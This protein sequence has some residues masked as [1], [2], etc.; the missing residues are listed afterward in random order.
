M[1]VNRWTIAKR[2]AGS[3]YRES[4]EMQREGPGYFLLF[5]VL[6][7]LA[8][9]FLLL[10]IS[11]FLLSGK[12][13]GWFPALEDSARPPALVVTTEEVVAML[14][15]LK[16]QALHLV[17]TSR[18][19]RSRIGGVPDLPDGFEWPEWQNVPLAFLAQIDLA[20]IDEQSVLPDLPKHGLLSFFYDQEQ[21]TWGFR[22]GDRGSWRVIYSTEEQQLRRTG[23]PAGVA[24]NGQYDEKKIEFLEVTTYPSL[25]RVT[26]QPIETSDETWD[27]VDALQARD[28]ADLPRHQLGG[29][30]S[31]VQGDDMELEC[32]LASNGV[33]VGNSTGYAS[34]EAAALKQGAADWVLLLQLDSD[35]ETNMMWG[36]L[37]MLY[38]WIRKDDLK[39]RKFS[40]CWMVLQCS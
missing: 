1:A 10:E 31:P 32:Q 4:R 20:E 24:E 3:F 27:E 5:A 2:K 19:V 7:I 28:F 35:D 17:E 23:P 11:I 33:D 14:K 38:F 29:L 30:P 34:P 21:S 18:D 12:D 8:L 16:Q 22:P 40:D 6:M 36:D 37:G 15:P 13:I 9:P 25:D 39:A 26:D